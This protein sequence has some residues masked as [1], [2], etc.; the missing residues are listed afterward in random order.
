MAEFQSK[1]VSKTPLMPNS[2]K[3][4]K[5]KNGASSSQ[6]SISDQLHHSLSEVRRLLLHFLP[7]KGRTAIGIICLSLASIFSLGF[8][9][10]A[11]RLI[12][13]ALRGDGTILFGIR[14]VSLDSIAL[15]LLVTIILQTL[16]TF[17]SARIFNRIGQLA[18]ATLRRETYAHMVRLPM[19]FFTERR[20]GELTSRISNDIG[21]IES[22]IVNAV[23]RAIEQLVLLTGGF[24]LIMQTSIRLTTVMLCT[25]PVVIG[26]TAMFSE[27]LR[28]VSKEM[29]DR[30]AEAN[31]LVEETFQA[32]TSVK[33][34][35]NE[36]FE[37]ARYDKAN[38]EAVRAGVRSS[39]RNAKFSCFISAIIFTEI[40]AV[41]W[42]G[43]RLMQT[44]L[45]SAGELTSFLLYSTF[46]A[47][48]IGQ[49]AN[50]FSQI[51]KA[52]G[53]TSRV[54]DL[55]KE[56]TEISSN[57]DA[58][59]L[60][61]DLMSGR[62]RGAV[63]FEGVSFSYPSRPGHTALAE[64]T[65]STPPSA[66]TAFVGP[67]GAGKTTIAAL[68]L[69]LY[70]PSNGRIFVDGM[71]IREY[72]LSWLREQISIVPQDIILFGGSISENIGYGR[73]GATESEIGQA[74]KDANADEF[75]RALP[76]G[77]ATM[78]GERGTKL[79]GGQRQ[80]IAIARAILRNPSILIL[81]E[82]TSSLDH[83]NETLVQS[84]LETAMRGRTTFI[85]AHRL[86][87]ILRAN[88]IIAIDS[89]RL[90]EIGAPESLRAKQTGLFC[91]FPMTDT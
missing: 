43:A 35:G 41:I 54:H 26:A 22:A 2:K 68:L 36:H 12:D 64:I 77:Y 73:V 57:S 52:A 6:Y 30:L 65:F 4:S 84:A 67:S 58:T 63:R 3:S 61:A 86:T 62:L 49:V 60:G 1:P 71:D 23:P 10:F 51:Q 40:V 15:L 14:K 75:I 5:N 44:G 48:A 45:I 32:I 82:A 90:V 42:Y 72:P 59:A 28:R 17:A 70:D 76:E 80:R 7:Y 19:V 74:A 9:F 46:I 56:Q 89:G 78:V 81:D 91:D 31:T 21:Q 53:A 18:L 39:Y 29:Q 16:V 27:Q 13:A 38:A 24:V 50:I 8:P 87:T 25:I 33:V 37:I 88:L 55:L 11:G 66:I 79:S 69:R 83:K 20:V 47:G 85:I 34:F